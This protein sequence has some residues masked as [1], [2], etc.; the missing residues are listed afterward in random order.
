M[1]LPGRAHRGY[2]QFGREATWGTA[3]TVTH[4]IPFV[5]CDTKQIGG[6]IDSEMMNGSRWLHGIYQGPRYVET[7]L[8]VE[9]WYAG[10]LLLIDGILGGANAF[11]SNQG[12][13][14]GANP[15]TH[16]FLGGDILNSYTFEII[17]GEIPSAVKCQRLVGA[18]IDSFELTGE[19]GTGAGAIC[20]ATIRLLAKSYLSNVDV[21]GSL[22]A[23]TA[24][25]VLFHEM[26]VLDGLEPSATEV[27]VSSF[28]VSINNHLARRQGN[29]TVFIL[30]P[31][32]EAFAEISIRLTKEFQTRLMLDAFNA[33]TAATAT[34]PTLIFGNSITKRITIASPGTAVIPEYGHPING[35][36][37]IMQEVTWKHF[38]P[39][40]AAG[41][42]SI[43]VENQQA[44]ITT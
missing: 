6:T 44:T 28:T 8:V 40:S 15:Y 27:V 19:R 38:R 1:G 4:R 2:I 17:E 22:S 29:G 9:L 43:V 41:P 24:I 14:T 34:Q 31:V 37:I 26:N 13:T 42:L 12:S 39:N 5:S 20:R 32:P 36:G 21:T 10:M 18:K 23:V 30:E 3:A 7:T 33:F 35:P 16:T 11:G 25:P